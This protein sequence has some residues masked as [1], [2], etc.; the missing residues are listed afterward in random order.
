MPR[1]QSN[2]SKFG[3]KYERPAGPVGTTP[4]T[5]EAAAFLDRP[6][7]APVPPHTIRYGS[8]EW[9]CNH[10]INFGKHAGCTVGELVARH[11]NYANWLVAF[12]YDG[13]NTHRALT[14]VIAARKRSGIS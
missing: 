7:S 8:L 5:P 9:A 2:Q 3:S 1:T 12:L 4:L 14:V 6:P 13:G 10:P 11:P